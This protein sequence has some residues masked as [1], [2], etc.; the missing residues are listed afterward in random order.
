MENDLRLFVI[1]C[2]V[3]AECGCVPLLPLSQPAVLGEEIELM[4]TQPGKYV[5][6]DMHR[7]LKE[8]R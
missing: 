1:F 7:A 4:T 8:H 2:D 5:A 6:R 3:T